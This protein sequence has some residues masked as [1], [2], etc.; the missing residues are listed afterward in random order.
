MHPC[1]DY[2][3]IAKPQLG[4]LTVA[5]ISCDSAS[6]GCSIRFLMAVLK[7]NG[8]KQI[9][10][11]ARS[12]SLSLSL[13]WCFSWG[14]KKLGCLSLFVT[15][16]VAHSTCSNATSVQHQCPEAWQKFSHL[17]CARDEI[18]QVCLITKIHTK[19]H[20]FPSP[21]LTKLSL[22]RQIEI[23]TCM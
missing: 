4:L 6:H 17:S 12:R 10:F 5:L 11:L 21:W 13:L 15:R 16:H 9:G 2:A 1:D 23:R 14:P 19:F 18:F 7:L 8:R 3:F 22:Q 20:P